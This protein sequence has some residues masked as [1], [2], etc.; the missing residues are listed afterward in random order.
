MIFFATKARR[1]KV[2]FCREDGKALSSCISL[3]AF[4]AKLYSRLIFL[5]AIFFF[6]GKAERRLACLLIFFVPSC[7]C[8]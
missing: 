4:V 8:G 3:C 5:P 1:H 2:F 7:L 6:A